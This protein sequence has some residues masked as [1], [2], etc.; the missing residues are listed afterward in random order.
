MV[1]LILSALFQAQIPAD[2]YGKTESQILAMGPQKWYDFFTAKAGESTYAMSNAYGIYGDIAAKR[3]DRLFAV[4]TSHTR[5]IKKVGKAVVEFGSDMVALGSAITGGGTMWGPIGLSSYAE[6]QDVIYSLLRPPKPKGH[7]IVRAS[8]VQKLLQSVPGLLK[9]NRD[10]LTPEQQSS[11]RATIRTPSKPSTNSASC[12]QPCHR[13][14]KALFSA[15]AGSRRNCST[16]PLP[17]ES[18]P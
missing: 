18:A 14:T 10:L 9:S 12:F 13:T 7:N 3:N 8:E 6:A 2:T 5:Q 17:K 11:L 16:L 15:S 4:N 1:A